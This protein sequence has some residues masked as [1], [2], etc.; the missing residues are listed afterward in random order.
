[1]ISYTENPLKKP[2]S[3][4]IVRREASVSKDLITAI[5]KEW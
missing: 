2:R 3:F 5:P 4:R 1:M